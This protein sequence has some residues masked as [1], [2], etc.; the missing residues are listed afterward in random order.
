MS[1]QLWALK[2]NEQCEAESYLLI[3]AS[4][5]SHVLP[6]VAMKVARTS[7][8]HLIH[9]FFGH[10]RWCHCWLFSISMWGCGCMKMGLQILR[11]KEPQ[12][13]PPNQDVFQCSD[14]WLS[15]RWQQ[16][17]GE[18]ERMRGS[19]SGQ[20]IRWGQEGTILSE[21]LISKHGSCSTRATG[22]GQPQIR[23]VRSWEAQTS[24][25][26]FSILS[27]LSS[28][29]CDAGLPAVLGEHET[30]WCRS[31]LPTLREEDMSFAL[32][33]GFWIQF[34]YQVPIPRSPG[35][36]SQWM[37]APLGPCYC[38]LV[39]SAEM[40]GFTFIWGYFYSQSASW[41]HRSH[42]AF[43]CPWRVIKGPAVVPSLRSWWGSRVQGPIWNPPSFLLSFWSHFR[44]ENLF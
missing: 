37:G 4:D 22:R 35:S 1:G 42:S 5:M 28:T 36:K 16:P 34:L 43:L 25:N 30:A 2:G 38:S 12:S 8:I 11:S 17:P 6:L 44:S 39:N 27:Y 3:L 14:P 20:C 26:L 24:L 21:I 32:F 13:R 23:F 10:L 7:P 41:G 33:F 9:I 18:G 15:H 19:E 29:P 40:F 31:R